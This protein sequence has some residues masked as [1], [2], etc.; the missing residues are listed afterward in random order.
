MPKPD[1]KPFPI[2]SP[3]A[4]LL[5]KDEVLAHLLEGDVEQ[6]VKHDA[7]EASEGPARESK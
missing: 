7:G 4:E 5:E 6:L 2:E 3:V 1:S